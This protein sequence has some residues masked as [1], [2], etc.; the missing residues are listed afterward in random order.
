M[1]LG[2]CFLSSNKL[3]VFILKDLSLKL[4]WQQ[5][6]TPPCVCCSRV[7]HLP[8]TPCV[9]H[10]LLNFV[11]V[12]EAWCQTNLAAGGTRSEDHRGVMRD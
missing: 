11:L 2:V 7:P 1:V 4:L 8:L 6:K 3:E 9:L 5:C 10:I 12:S